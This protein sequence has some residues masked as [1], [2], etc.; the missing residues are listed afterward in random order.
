MAN[1]RYVTPLD[2]KPRAPLAGSRTESS[3]MR[4][5]DLIN[6]EKVY[7]ATGGGVHMYNVGLDACACGK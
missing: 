3:N 5:P 1:L 7:Y 2:G 4:D 6:V